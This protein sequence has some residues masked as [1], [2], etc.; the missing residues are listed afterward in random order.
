MRDA[1]LADLVLCLVVDNSLSIYSVFS[2][3][4]EGVNNSQVNVLRVLLLQMF[5]PEVTILNESSDEVGPKYFYCFLF[6]AK[7]RNY[8]DNVPA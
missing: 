4:F 6:N 8:N 3:A 7:R 5:R 1:L 2:Q